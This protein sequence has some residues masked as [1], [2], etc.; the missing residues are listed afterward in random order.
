MLV[1]EGDTAKKIILFYLPFLA[2]TKQIIDV[3]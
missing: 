1:T 3:A 2:I